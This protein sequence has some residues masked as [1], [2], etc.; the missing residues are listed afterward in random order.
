MNRTDAVHDLYLSPEGPTALRLRDS[1]GNVLSRPRSAAPGKARRSS[2]ASPFTPAIPVAF[3]GATD[4][5]RASIMLCSIAPIIA[6]RALLSR[7][8]A[9][10]CVFVV[11]ALQNPPENCRFLSIPPARP[12]FPSSFP[13][14]FPI[15][16][17]LFRRCGIGW[18]WRWCL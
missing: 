14:P 17:H 2:A 5:C 13:S 10:F 15:S 11:Y 3:R 12:F 8:C 9:Y 1:P 7:D 4:V 18:L 6:V 16:P